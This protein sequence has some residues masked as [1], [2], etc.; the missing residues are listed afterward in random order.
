MNVKKTMNMKNKPTIPTLHQRENFKVN[1]M[2]TF[3]VVRLDTS[4]QSIEKMDKLY[5]HAFG[6]NFPMSAQDYAQIIVNGIVIGIIH[7]EENT[8][9]GM[10]ALVKEWEKSIPVDRPIFAEHKKLAYSNHTMIHEDYRSTGISKKIASHTFDWLREEKLPGVR[11]SVAPD[12]FRN[13]GFL[14]KTGFKIVDFSP[15]HF[16]KGLHRF[17]GVYM[18]A[19]PNTMYEHKNYTIQDIIKKRIKVFDD[20]ISADELSTHSIIAVRII[21][22]NHTNHANNNFDLF[23]QLLNKYRYQGVLLLRGEQIWGQFHQN[24]NNSYL[25]CKRS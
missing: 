1:N 23:G 2:G 25:V 24:S 16:G 14:T 18:V 11:V 21:S 8:L 9:I 3:R 15:N 5:R 13:I 17:H 7:N 6:S 12:N 22:E 10:R 20:S 4:A 19:N